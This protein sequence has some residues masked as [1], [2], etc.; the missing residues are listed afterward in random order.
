VLALA[1]LL[2]G[3]QAERRPTNT[4]SVS[5]PI[6]E[7]KPLAGLKS[8][9]I[10]IAPSAQFNAYNTLRTSM[11]GGT[12]TL[13]GGDR[14]KAGGQL[15]ESQSTYEKEF[16]STVQAADPALATRI[17]QSYQGMA[18]AARDG[19]AGTYRRLRYAIDVGILRLASLKTR[20]ALA[21]N[22]AAEAERWFS[23]I[24]NRFDLSKDVQPLGAAWKRVQSGPV[25]AAVQK[26][27]N[28]SL[29][30]YMATKVKAE[31]K[32][33]G[34]GLTEKNPPKARWETAGGVAY[35]DILKETYTEQLGEAATKKMNDSLVAIDAAIVQNDEGKARSGIEEVNKQLEQFEQSLAG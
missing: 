19:D 6:D 12:T 3:C 24:A 34:D 10:T 8:E 22:D 25:D 5:A 7:A 30:G 14:A 16:A 33:A 35:F 17:T 29:A 21:R 20:E 18:V 32:G 1:L 15:A 28:L 23:A 27:V 26:A 2:V 13:E 31:L 9:A 4:T 11:N